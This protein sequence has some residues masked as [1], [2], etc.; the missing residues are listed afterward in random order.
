MLDEIERKGKNRDW[1]MGTDDEKLRLVHALKHACQSLTFLAVASCCD[2]DVKRY[3]K[4]GL[5]A[6]AAAL[7]GKES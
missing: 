6:I 3:C 7:A 4:N 5:T 1:P 2:R